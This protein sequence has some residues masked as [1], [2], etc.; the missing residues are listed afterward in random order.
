MGLGFGKWDFM[1][2]IGLGFISKKNNKKGN[3]SKI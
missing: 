1:H 2:Y 3:G